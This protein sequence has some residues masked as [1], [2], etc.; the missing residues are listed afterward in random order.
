MEIDIDIALHDS[1][2]GPAGHWARTATIGDPI[3]L[4]LPSEKKIKH[5]DA[6]WYLFI[7]DPC[8]IPAALA[9]M[10]DIPAD[11]PIYAVIEAQSKDDKQL[12]DHIESMQTR[13]IIQSTQCVHTKIADSYITELDSFDFPETMPGVF[14]AG[15]SSVIKCFK[16]WARAKWDDKLVHPYISPYWKSNLDQDEHKRFKSKAK[17][18]PMVQTRPV[19]HSKMT[20]QQQPSP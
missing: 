13:W 12:F 4:T 18:P 14:A 15:E 7:A 6:P 8:S 17:S 3:F 9:A 19:S 2:S 11:T 20:P 5:F 1:P 10:E 16:Q